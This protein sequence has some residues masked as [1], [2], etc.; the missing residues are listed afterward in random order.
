MQFLSHY[1]VKQFAIAAVIGA[2]VV[3][4]FATFQFIYLVGVIKPHL[5]ILPFT[6][7]SVSGLFISYWVQRFQLA[8]KNLQEKNE[9]LELVLEGS[10]LGLWDWYPQTNIVV[11][12]ERWCQL[13]GYKLSEVEPTYTS[14]ESRVH[15]DDLEQCSKDIQ[16]H[17][18][19]KT[20]F[21]RNV[22]RMK[23]KD[24]HWVYMLDRGRIVKRDAQGK[25]LLFSGT[26]TDIT[27]L[28]Q[29]EKS[30]ERSNLKLK[31]LSLIDGLTGLKNRRA[32]DQQLKQSWGFLTRNQTPFS[33]L[34]LDIDFF[35]QFNDE[36]GHL[37]GDDCLKQIAEV[38]QAN[39]KRTNDIACRYGGEEFLILF[40]GVKADQ[41]VEFSNAIREQV[42]ALKIPHNGS[43][44]SKYVTLSIGISACDKTHCNSPKDSIDQADKALYMAKQQGRNR[45]KLFEAD[46]DKVNNKVKP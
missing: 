46:M 14:W 23:H 4:T 13:L 35:K 24:G 34:M 2:L 39:V 6:V 41:A 25:P 40:S 3:T 29:V 17:M 28:K 38:L 42:E 44:C 15:P 32:L 36:Y 33:T 43:Q 8:Q 11:F 19:G 27:H 37:A 16:K 45:V 9:H 7:G 5:Y 26:H 10:N 20:P 30:L 18:D 31:E 22:H 21:Y 1:S 12:D